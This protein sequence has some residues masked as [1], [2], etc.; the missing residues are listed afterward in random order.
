MIFRHY[1]LYLI[2]CF[3]Q[4][5]NWISYYLK[6]DNRSKVSNAITKKREDTLPFFSV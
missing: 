3:E 2:L 5:G 4:V 1:Y 6:R